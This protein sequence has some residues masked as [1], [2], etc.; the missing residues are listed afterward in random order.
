[1]RIFEKLL[2]FVIISI[3]LLYNINNAVY[4][5]PNITTQTPVKVAVF[6]NNFND[7]FISNPGLFMNSNSVVIIVK[8]YIE[9]EFIEFLY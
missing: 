6:L 5:S 7:P 8:T 9:F 3:L 4:A 2:S 1:M